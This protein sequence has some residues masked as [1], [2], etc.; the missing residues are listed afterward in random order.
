MKLKTIFAIFGVLLLFSCNK[1]ETKIPLTTEKTTEKYDQIK[2]MDWLLG[3]WE[4]L[5]QDGKLKLSW[6]KENDSAFAGNSY[7]FRGKDTLRSESLM[8][9]QSGDSLRFIVREASG[10]KNNSEKKQILLS[11]KSFTGNKYIFENS[12]NQFPKKVSYHKISN[13]TLLSETSGMIDGKQNVEEFKLVQ[14]K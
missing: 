9:I 12:E 4:N 10:I 2:E 8:L 14:I 3:D 6:K 1:K 5:Q 13:D 11:L 7:V